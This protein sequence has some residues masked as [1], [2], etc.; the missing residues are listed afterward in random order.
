[1]PAICYPQEEIVVNI[2][3]KGL[4]R[5]P[6]VF[7]ADIDNDAETI[8]GEVRELHGHGAL[9]SDKGYAIAANAK[10]ILPPV[11]KRFSQAVDEDIDDIL[12]Y[13]RLRIVKKVLPT[14]SE[15]TAKCPAFD[16]GK[17][18]FDKALATYHKKCLDFMGLQMGTDGFD[19]LELNDN[20]NLLTI[21][22]G[23]YKFVGTLSSAVTDYG[24]SEQIRVGFVQKDNARKAAGGSS[25]GSIKSQLQ[26][27]EPQLIISMLA[28][29]YMVNGPLDFVS[30][31]GMTYNLYRL[32]GLE[33]HKYENLSAE[34][35]YSAVAK[36]LKDLKERAKSERPV[37]AEETEAYRTL[38]R[39]LWL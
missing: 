4:G 14:G 23:H 35:A 24:D 21:C 10:R 12:G 7:E 9:F 39:M 31:D 1:M 11:V 20:R 5:N 18:P 13:L 29:I 27:L 30:T 33:L 37:L 26:S 3:P 34:E 32:H 38:R 36:R 2:E 25:A 19:V 15:G 8:I 16:S 17:E 6:M 28:T 22:I